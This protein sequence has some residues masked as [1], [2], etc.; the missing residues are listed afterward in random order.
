[1]RGRRNREGRGSLSSLDLVPDVARDDILWALAELNRRERTQADILF[2]LNDRLEVHGVDPI[3]KSAFNRRSMRM[4]AAARRIKEQREV[5]SGIA[6]QFTPESMDENNI[7]LGQMIQVLI[8][9][10]LDD[11][12]RAPKDA[13]SLAR[14]FLATIQGQKVSSERRRKLQEEY[15]K[16]T[17]EAVEKIAEEAGLTDERIKQLREKFLGVRPK[18]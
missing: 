7:V 2:E 10:L 14:A 18:Q 13:L 16:K 17:G 11:P 15:E 4:A 3:S 12:D 9:E 6:D 8:S 5:F 1:M